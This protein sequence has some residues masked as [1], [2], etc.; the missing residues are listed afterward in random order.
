ML[1]LSKFLVLI[2]GGGDLASGVA[3]RLFRSGFPVLITELPQPLMVRRTVSFAEAVYQGQVE[4]E[5]VTAVHVPDVDTALRVIDPQAT[6]R[7][8]VVLVDPEAACRAAL[9]PL[10]VVD[11][12]M[13][14]RN[15]GTTLHD[16]PLVIALGPGF[17]AGVD[18]HAVIE[19][20]RGHNLG[21]P[22]YHGSAEPDT[23]VPGS[24]GDK[25]TERLLRTPVT[26]IIASHAEIGD[27]VVAGQVVAAVGNQSVRTEIDGV[28][29]GLIRSGVQVSAH[30]KI[31]DVDPRAESVHCYRVS[32]KSLAVGGGVLEAV[33]SFLTG[34]AGHYNED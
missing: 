2:K 7:R 18:C 28:L 22:L 6:N 5:G 1:D 9:H 29:R 25:T 14:K 26:G 34:I 24:I 4:I 31:G 13:A 27:H 3:L 17:T 8:V 21:R 23:G 30:M 20:N 32:D 10:V 19:T 33:L 11:A 16:A 15:L 12:I